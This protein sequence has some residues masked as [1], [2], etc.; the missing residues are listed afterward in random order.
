M[1]L[2]IIEH[3]IHLR[4]KDNWEGEFS[5]KKNRWEDKA[6]EG[7]GEGELFTEDVWK[8]HREINCYTRWGP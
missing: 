4:E 6:E 7:L 5:G 2:R 1:I 8:T 3:R